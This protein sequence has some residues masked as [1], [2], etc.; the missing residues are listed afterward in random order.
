MKKILLLVVLLSSVSC[1]KMIDGFQDGVVTNMNSVKKAKLECYSA[2][3]KFFDYQH[4]GPI[5][6]NQNGGYRITLMDKLITVNGDCV[7]T[8]EF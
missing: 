7:L 6:E 8:E 1:A 3:G 4:D 5:W 2:G